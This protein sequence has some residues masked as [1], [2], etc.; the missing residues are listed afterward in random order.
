MGQKIHPTGFRVGVT[1]EHNVK[2][3]AN[4]RT[5]PK[6]LKEDQQIRQ[7]WDKVAK[8]YSSLTLN[9][10]ITKICIQRQKTFLQLR[11][12]AGRPHLLIENNG[13]VFKNF[14][15]KLKML[16]SKNCRF[17]VIRDPKGS[18]AAITVAKTIAVG[19]EK[20]MAYKRILKQISLRLREESIPGF[21]IQIS[22]RLNGVPIAR[23]YWIREGRVP[24]Q[25]LDADIDYS[26]QEA[27]TKYGVIGIKVTIFRPG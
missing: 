6:I 10:Q 8:K 25:T 2:W 1:K 17:Q 21:K 12:Y 22:G 23:K 5:F 27:H 9:A 26:L 24:L 20:R 18:V 15:D 13:K 14:R 7:A 19:L 4:F 16:S 3:F 11:F